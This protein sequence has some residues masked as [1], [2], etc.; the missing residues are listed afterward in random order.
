MLLGTL[1][2]RLNQHE[3]ANVNYKKILEID[4]RFA[5]AANNLAWNYAEHGG[6][7]DVALE[8]ARKA[9]DANPQNPYFADTLGWIYYR[10]DI[11][12]TAVSLLK[13]VSERLGGKDPNVLFHLGQAYYKNGERNAARDALAK[14]LAINPNLPGADEAT[15]VLSKLGQKRIS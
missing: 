13:D 6:D 10:K 3:K 11:Y 14:A 4:E 12:P 9:R 15:K 1:H 5:A 8:L 2:D 7:I